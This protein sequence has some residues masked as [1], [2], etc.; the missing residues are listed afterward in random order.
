MA[1]EAVIFFVCEDAGFVV[2]RLASATTDLALADHL[3]RM[4]LAAKRLGCSIRLRE[5]S[6]DL[7]ELLELLGLSECLGVEVRGEPEGREQL[8]VEEVVDAGDASA[9]DL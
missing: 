5:V 9:G 8:R 4:Q 1:A 2:A 3:A 7:G 6:R